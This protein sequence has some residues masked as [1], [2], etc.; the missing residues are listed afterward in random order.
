[1]KI[2]KVVGIVLLVVLVL[3][4][5]GATLFLGR[6]VTSAVNLGGPAALGVPMSLEKADVAL[7]RGQIKLKGLVIGNPEGFDTKNLV[8]LGQLQV[9]LSM[10]S[11]LSKRILI[12]KILVDAPRISYEQSLSGSN[13]AKLQEQLGGTGETAQAE[14]PEKAEKKDESGT[15][16]EI[17]QILITNGRISYSAPGMG[18]VAIPIPLPTIEL[19]DVGKESEGASLAEVIGRVFGAVFDGVMKAV[20]SSGQLLGKGAKAVGDGAIKGA[21][22]VGGAAMDAAGAVGDGVKG[23]FKPKK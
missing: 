8:E 12:H 18:S 17:T 3:G 2:L 11:L 6:V 4:F 1:V 14:E 13:L 7:L 16:V 10:R 23:L 20:T 9:F 19:N 15:K 21:G 22:A 5:I